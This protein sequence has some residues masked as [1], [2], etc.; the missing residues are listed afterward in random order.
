MGHVTTGLAKCDFLYEV[1]CNHTSILH[2]YED[3][4]LK[5]IDVT[6]LTFWNHMTLLVT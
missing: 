1:N 3:I 6:T 5:Y 4:N 2:G